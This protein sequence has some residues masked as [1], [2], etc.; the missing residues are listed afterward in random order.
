M[1]R[2][3]AALAM[4]ALVLASSTACTSDDAPDGPM[5]TAVTTPATTT[6]PP[7]PTPTAT[8]TAAAEGPIDRTDTDLGIIFTDLPDVTGDAKAAVDVYTLYEADFWKALTT[9]KIPAEL[10]AITSPAVYTNVKSQVDGNAKAGTTLSGANRVQ[11][12][13]VKADADSASIETCQVSSDWLFT[14]KDG[15]TKTGPEAG[16]DPIIIKVTMTHA[17]GSPW[18]VDTYTAGDAC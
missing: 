8:P 10:R 9:A 14:L 7:S 2:G 6:A 11:L 15:S 1:H 4:A 12:V 17:A 5:T 3:W 18:T 13:D 16:F